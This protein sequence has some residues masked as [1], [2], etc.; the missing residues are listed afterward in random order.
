MSYDLD[1]YY[2]RQAEY[3]LRQQKYMAL[4]ND[5][6]SA[7]GSTAQEAVDNLV[8]FHLDKFTGEIALKPCVG[9]SKSKGTRDVAIFESPQWRFRNYCRC[10]SCN[11][12]DNLKAISELLF[13]KP[14]LLEESPEPPPIKYITLKILKRK[15]KARDKHHRIC[16]RKGVLYEVGEQWYQGG[17]LIYLSSAN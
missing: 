10:E 6:T 2:L 14:A 1:D 11:G 16:E 3:N 5:G 9:S 17:G 7:T 8:G 13:N 15:R 4:L 12:Q